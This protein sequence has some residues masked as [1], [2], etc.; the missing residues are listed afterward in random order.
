MAV[1][2]WPVATDKPCLE[3]GFELLLGLR[4]PSWVKKSSC[5]EL[6]AALRAGSAGGQ[7]SAPRLRVRDGGTGA[8]AFFGCWQQEFCRQ[9]QAWDRVSK[10]LITFVSFCEL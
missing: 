1:S 4:N 6:R 8:A 3:L 7:C 10:L 2:L 9:C 5:A